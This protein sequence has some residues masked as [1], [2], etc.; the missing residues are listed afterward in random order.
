VRGFS[1]AA[2]YAANRAGVAHVAPDGGAGTEE[3]AV[4]E[5]IS[6]RTAAWIRRLAK[7][8]FD[9]NVAFVDALPS[10]ATGNG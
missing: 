5:A 9:D 8:V 1:R 7:S 2:E 6:M 3:P 10:P 4:I